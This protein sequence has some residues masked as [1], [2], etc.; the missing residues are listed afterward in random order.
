MGM[1]EKVPEKDVK[2]FISM[3]ELWVPE[4]VLEWAEKILRQQSAEIAE[5]RAAH[6]DKIESHRLGYE[7][8]RAANAA[9]TEGVVEK[10]QRL[11]RENEDLRQ[12]LVGMASEKEDTP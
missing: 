8:G 3:L 7:Q 12:I 2:D 1:P 9:F 5:L 4:P 11:E 10:L 6:N